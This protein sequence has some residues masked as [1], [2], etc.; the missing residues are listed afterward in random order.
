MLPFTSDTAEYNVLRAGDTISA[1]YTLP[2]DLPQRTGNSAQP[3][4]NPLSPHYNLV[5]AYGWGWSS[6]T[7][8]YDN[9]Q[10][11]PAFRQLYVRQALQQ[12]LDQTTDVR[13]AYRG[14]AEA[15]TGPV[16][17]VP[18]NQY[19]APVERG[20][21][22]Y[23][24]DTAVARKRLTSH[25]WTARDGV[26]TC[27]AP[28]TGANRCGPGVTSGTTLSVTV[29]YSSGSTAYQQIMQQWQTDAAKAGIVLNLKP[30]EFNQL[31]NDTSSCHGSGPS[32]YWQIADFG[33]STYYAVPT[34]EQILLPGA[35]GNIMNVDDPKLTALVDATLHSSSPTAFA[36]YETY[37]AQQLPGQ[38]NTPIRYAIEATATN[39]RGVTYPAV[40]TGRTPEDWYFVK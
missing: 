7:L 25:G 24:F 20:A 37:A 38:I 30:E 27:T 1:G 19:V 21:G 29:L 18:D 2:Q 13:V 28:G 11:G 22:P 8:N 3:V 26:L 14:Y 39:I 35:S 15:T 4:R 17:V 16:N 34:G 23:P 10:L 31:E 33:Y 32:C 36:D 5:P 9:P 40:S 6:A 12:V